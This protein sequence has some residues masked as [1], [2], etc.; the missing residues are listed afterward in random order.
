MDPVDTGR[1]QPGVTPGTTPPFTPDAGGKFDPLKMGQPSQPQQQPVMRPSFLQAFLSSLGPALAGGLHAEPGAPFGTGLGGALAGIE[2]QNRYGQALGM[3]QQEM[4][5][6]QAAEA[7]AAQQAASTQAYQA[8]ETSRLQQLTPLEV[9]QQQMQQDLMQAQI[10]FFGDPTNLQGAVDQ[11]T[12]TLGKME[13]AEQ[14]QLNAAMQEAQLTHKF[15]P[16]NAAVGK[17]S[18][19]RLLTERKEDL[20]GLKDYLADK[21]LD[22]LIKNKNAATFIAWKAKQQ[23]GALVLGNMLGSGGAGSA[24]DQVA[25]KWGQ[26]GEMP[27]GLARSP[28]TTIAVMKRYAQLHPDENLAANKARYAS[29]K[30]SQA[31]LQK[32]FDAVSAFEKT[33]QKN[34]DQILATGKNVPD[35]GTR[36]ANVPVR[37]IDDKM[38][39]TKEMA[40]FRVAMATGRAETMR[41]LASA[42][43]AGTLTNEARH[44]GE[45]LL[46]GNMTFP[47]M[48]AAVEQFRTDMANRHTSYQDQLNEINQLLSGKKPAAEAAPAMEIKLPSGKTITI[49]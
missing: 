8:A 18:Q 25:E 20:P 37:M 32:Q 6:R 46:S 33:A 41:V 43:A 48:Q 40:K 9:K 1:V 35:L 5:L 24:L 10:K 26:T 17:I 2:E 13:P 7:R 38:L 45:E 44:E 4:A 36:F 22:P 31:G 42:N 14:S 28:G 39:G 21:T 12:Q 19:D 15:D 16:I 23:P 11:A 29:L 27:P 3:Q 34:L 47:A 30:N 49:K